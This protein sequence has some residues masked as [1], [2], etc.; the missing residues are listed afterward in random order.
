MSKVK[1]KL[2]SLPRL[3]EV[4][5]LST[6]AFEAY[7]A[8]EDKPITATAALASDNI[9]QHSIRGVLVTKHPAIILVRVLWK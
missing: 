9:T 1:V 3:L 8:S 5:H 4:S 2:S 6:I 7:I